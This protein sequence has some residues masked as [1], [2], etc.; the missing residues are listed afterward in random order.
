MVAFATQSK[1]RSRELRRRVVARARVWSGSQWSDVCILNVSSRG[2]LIQT[3]RP[4]AERST[5]EI[6]RGDHVIVARV[7]WSNAGRSGLRS[8][9]QLPVEDILSLEQSRALQLIASNGLIHDRRRTK[10]RIVVDP[11]LRGRAMEFLAIGAIAA[12]LAI[13]MAA[14]AERALSGPLASASAALG[15]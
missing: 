1:H 11:R 13:G 5:V 9:Q 6:L 7:M 12:S 10:R 14:M 4:V 15:G 8:E 3:S 2:L